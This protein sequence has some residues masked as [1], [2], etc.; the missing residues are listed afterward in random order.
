MKAKP[1]SVTI[2]SRQPRP[3]GSTRPEQ[4]RAAVE[5][6]REHQPA[7]DQHDRL[8]QHDAADDEQHHADPHRGALDL[9]DDAAISWMSVGPGVCRA[10]A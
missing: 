3:I 7:D 4:P 1:A 10:S 9:A 2:A 5:D 8:G 6:H